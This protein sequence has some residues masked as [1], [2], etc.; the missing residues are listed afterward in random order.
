MLCGN[1]K[2]WHDTFCPSTT[3]APATFLPSNRCW[4]LIP[5]SRWN[6]SISTKILPSAAS[7]FAPLHAL[8]VLSVNEIKK[9]NGLKTKQF[10]AAFSQFLGGWP[11]QSGTFSVVSLAPDGPKWLLSS[12]H[13]M[14]PWFVPHVTKSSP[15]LPFL[16]SLIT[17]ILNNC[18]LWFLNFDE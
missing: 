15:S 1:F 14:K 9:L 12:S 4:L 10:P 5:T 2:S 3:S 16:I 8:S 17:I 13:E 7:L 6:F 18:K 11:R